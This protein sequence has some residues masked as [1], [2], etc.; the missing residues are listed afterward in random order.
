M[1]KRWMS[2]DRNAARIGHHKA[3]FT[4]I[5]LLVVVAIIAL[6]ISILL[7]SLNRAREQAKS[8]V[9]ANNLRQLGT[10]FAIYWSENDDKFFSYSSRNINYVYLRDIVQKLDDIMKCPSTRPKTEGEKDADG[11][12]RSGGGRTMWSW[13]AA[14]AA[15]PPVNSNDTLDG[16]KYLEGSYGFNGWL[17]D[18]VNKS[19][20]QWHGIAYPDQASRAPG[21]TDSGHPYHYKKLA[22]VKSPTTTP[23]MFD[24][25]TFSS[26]PVNQENP[27]EF[28]FQ[29]PASIS[30]ADLRNPGDHMFVGDALLRPLEWQLIR[31]MPDRHSNMQNNMSFADGHAELVDP[32]QQIFLDWGPMFEKNILNRRNIIKWPF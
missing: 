7:P 32:K 13:V 14:G 6:L 30:R 27:G 3:G 19:G 21:L 23:V 8:V 25:M 18:P 15:D 17:Y 9:C 29:W 26:H 5:E 1:S 10:S 22:N 12:H 31:S 2:W 16:D 20:F 4:L 24:S 28:A 11:W